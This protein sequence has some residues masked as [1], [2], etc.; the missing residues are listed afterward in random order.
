[1]KT[2]KSGQWNLQ[3][4]RARLALKGCNTP[5][6]KPWTFYKKNLTLISAKILSFSFKL[7]LP[8]FWPFKGGI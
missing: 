3:R 7:K 6:N 1:M 2:L 5:E 8:L 4:K